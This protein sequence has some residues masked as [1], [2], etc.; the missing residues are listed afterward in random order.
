MNSWIAPS[1]LQIFFGYPQRLVSIRKRG[2]CPNYL[3]Q[4]DRSGLEIALAKILHSNIKAVIYLKRT[5]AENFGPR[6]TVGNDFRPVW[7]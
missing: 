4:N 1:K 6:E 7:E 3:L 5:L 2:L